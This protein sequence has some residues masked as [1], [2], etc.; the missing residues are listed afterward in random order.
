MGVK[1]HRGCSLERVQ[2]YCPFA[3]PRLFSADVRLLLRHMTTNRH[4][5]I[6]IINCAGVGDLMNTTW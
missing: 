2:L 1:R 3:N 5:R 4:Q 6:R